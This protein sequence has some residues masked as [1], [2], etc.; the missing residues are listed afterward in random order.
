MNTMNMIEEIEIVVELKISF[1]LPKVVRQQFLG[2]VGTFIVSWYQVS[3]R[4]C[5]PKIIVIS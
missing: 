5:V 1:A 2:E 3:S 4:C